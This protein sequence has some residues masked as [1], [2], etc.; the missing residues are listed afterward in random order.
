MLGD[1][2]DWFFEEGAEVGEDYKALR[3]V[4]GICGSEEMQQWSRV[5]EVT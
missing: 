5:G 1:V 3:V 2:N 4:C